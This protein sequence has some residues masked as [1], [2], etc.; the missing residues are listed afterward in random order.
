MGDG[1]AERAVLGAL[2]VDVDPLVVAGGVRERVHALLGDL[3]PV[4]VAQMR[5]D[6]LP[7]P[8]D[9]FDVLGHG[10]IIADGDRPRS[11]P[12]P[13]AATGAQVN[14][15]FWCSRDIGCSSRA[16]SAYSKITLSTLPENST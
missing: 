6:E 9:S 10:R 16:I 4:R 2:G 3:E 5:A 12:S 11:I 15:I 1:A 14:Q 7:E 8:C 13:A